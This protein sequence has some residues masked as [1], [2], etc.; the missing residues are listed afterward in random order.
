M[1]TIM[2]EVMMDPEEV[3]V[4]DF[5]ALNAWPMLVVT[6]LDEAAYAGRG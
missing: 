4:Y 6:I 5:E 3:E 2:S 1:P